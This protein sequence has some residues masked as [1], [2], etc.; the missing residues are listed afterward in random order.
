MDPQ[1]KKYL[2]ALIV[3][4]ALVL[5][6]FVV[7]DP[8]EEL[9]SQQ[10][11]NNQPAVNDP[12]KEFVPANP[13][14]PDQEAVAQ[15]LQIP[16]EIAFLPDKSML[17]TERPGTLRHLANQKSI[18]IQGVAH[19][20]EGG[21]LGL[22]L[23]PNFESNGFIYLYFTTRTGGGLTNRVERYRFENDALSERQVII[24]NI[25]GSSNHDG[26][27]I[28]FGPDG[29]L[30]I[31]AG[32]AD[33]PNSAQDTNALSGK[34]L[35]IGDDG[36]L[37]GDNPFR[38]A[39]YSYGHRNPQGLAWDSQGRLWATEHGPSGNESGFDELNLIEKGKNYGWPVIRGGQTQAGME[40]PIEHSGPSQTWAPSGMAY[41][42][43]KLYFSG[44]RGEALYIATI[45]SGNTVSL[46]SYLSRQYGRL[47]AVVVG[48]EGDIYLSTSNRDGRGTVKAGD[49]KIIRVNP[50]SLN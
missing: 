9:A 29:Y 45:N 48:P 16:W 17:V 13:Q 46:R 32:D 33:R 14:R 38:N 11:T 18:P 24:E 39:V 22:V 19:V 36:S 26:G 30:Y 2:L 21:L 8:A 5:L 44:L 41:K 1:R 43:G 37:P 49:D 31:T 20:G 23:H 7:R 34:I 42:D 6:F 47:R 3:L 40:R 27:R 12:P 35:R 50:E 10:G 4:V 15:S 28:A 25:P